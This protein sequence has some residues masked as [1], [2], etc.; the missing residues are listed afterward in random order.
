[1]SDR[2]VA[3]EPYN[4]ADNRMDSW[5]RFA[6]GRP[7]LVRIRW[8]RTLIDAYTS[9]LD[10]PLSLAERAALPFALTRVPLG[11]VAALASSVCP[12]A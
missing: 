7:T 12:R 1:M 8:L 3:V 4:L 9:G 11:F 5:E 10:E 2:P 6:A